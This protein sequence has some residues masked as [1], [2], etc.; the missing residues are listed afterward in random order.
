MINVSG[1]TGFVGKVIVTVAGLTHS[2]PSDVNLLLVSPAG[3]NVLLMSHAGGAYGVTNITLTFDDSTPQPLVAGTPLVTGTYRPSSY[4]GGVSFP[5]PATAPPYGTALSTINTT[6]PNGFWS[7]LVLDDRPGD[8]GIIASGWSMTL[9][10]VNPVAPLADLAVG[11]SANPANVFLGDNITFNLGVTNLGPSAAPGVALNDTL[12]GGFAVVSTSPSQGSILQAGGALT[13]NVG[14]LAAG[15]SASLALVTSP[16]QGGNFINVASVSGAVTD[17]NP[18]N[19]SS[20]INVTVTVPIRTVLSGTITNG[21]FQ[22][23]V[24]A[25][26]N[27]IY[28]IQASPDLNLWLPVSTNSPA[29]DGT[30]TFI[31]P[32]SPSGSTRFYRAV[33]L[34]P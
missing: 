9:T 19:D 24:A 1:V 3:P 26:A 25:P 16:A 32:R 13:W 29:A 14:N 7:L 20:Q 18:G 30:I 31:D 5:S 8:A 28:V 17:Q 22:L 6:D 34:S 2:F 10:T 27:N 12:P 4:G 23:T 15:A 21:L 11:L 33:Q